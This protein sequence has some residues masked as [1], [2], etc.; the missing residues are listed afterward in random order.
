M[1]GLAVVPLSFAQQSVVV[2]DQLQGP[3]PV[4]NMARRALRLM[5]GCPIIGIGRIAAE[6]ANLYLASMS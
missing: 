4:Y 2:H 5:S 1:S 3:S 6:C